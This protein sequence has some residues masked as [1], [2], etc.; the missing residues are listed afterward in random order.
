[1][2]FPQGFVGIVLLR[3]QPGT[4]EHLSGGGG[5]Q[6]DLFFR[7]MRYF[8]IQWLENISDGMFGYFILNQIGHV[9][10]GH[11]FKLRQSSAGIQFY[12]FQQG[13]HGNCCGTKYSGVNA[14]RPAREYWPEGATRL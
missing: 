4:G 2:V 9:Q 14:Y 3:A 7:R 6:R 5:L 10:F 12:R 13:V 8:R 11:I 1:M